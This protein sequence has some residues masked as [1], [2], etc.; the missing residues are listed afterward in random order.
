MADR[1]QIVWKIVDQFNVLAHGAH[2][3]VSRRELNVLI[4][5][6]ESSGDPLAEDVMRELLILA[7]RAGIAAGRRRTVMSVAGPPVSTPPDDPEVLV[8]RI[9]EDLFSLQMPMTP[10]MADL[11]LRI[12]R[13]LT[14]E[15]KGLLLKALSEAEGVSKQGQ[16]QISDYVEARGWSMQLAEQMN[17]ALSL[18]ER[19]LLEDLA[20]RAFAKGR[21]VPAGIPKPSG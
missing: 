21:Q 18:E 1:D 13:R 8:A 16:L 12:V 4:A 6:L 19:S 7:Y 20:V 10:E 14:P 9:Q 5:A 15:K 3:P 2:A 17:L 11:L